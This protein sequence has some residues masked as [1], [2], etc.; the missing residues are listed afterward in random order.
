MHTALLMRC[1][2]YRCRW[3]QNCQHSSRQRAFIGNKRQDRHTSHPHDNNYHNH[4]HHNHHNHLTQQWHPRPQ[5]QQQEVGLR[6]WHWTEQ[7]AV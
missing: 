7:P 1:S 2:N 5:Q 4:S 3:H 6:P